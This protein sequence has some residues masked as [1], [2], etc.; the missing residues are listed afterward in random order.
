MATHL[1]AEELSN[2]WPWLKSY[3]E[4]VRWDI[5]VPFAPLWEVMDH[6]VAEFADKTAIDFLD[7]KYSYAD[8]GALV[9]KAAKG[10]QEIG[11]QKGVKVGLFLPNSPYTVI[12]FFAILKAGGTVVN[13]NPL[14]AERELASQIEDSETDIMVTLD[15]QVLYPRVETLMRNT[16][17]KRIIVCRMQ[18]SLPFPKNLLF[19]MVK[20]KDIA[21]VSSDDFVAHYKDLVGNDGRYTPVDVDVEEDVACLQYTGGT[22]GTPKGAM[23][24]HANLYGN[25]QQIDMWFHGREPGKERVVAV[26]PFFHVFGMTAIMLLGVWGGAEMVLL[27]RF[28]IDE[29]MQAIHKKKPTIFA[30]VP[31]MFTAM[32]NHPDRDKYDFTSLKYVNSGGASMPLEIMRKFEEKAGGAELRE[33]YGLSETSPVVSS[34]PFEGKRKAG[35]VGI[36]YPATI[37]QIVSLDDP[38]K[39]MPIGEQ[40]EIAVRGPQVM[41]GYWQKPEET[42]AVMKDGRFLTGDIGYMDDE[43]YLFIVDR[44]KEMIIAGGYNIYPR[45]VEEAIYEH[46]AVEEVAVIGVADEYR[47]ETVKAVIK[48]RAGESLTEEELT[49]FLQDKLSKIEQPKIVE[50]RD[51]ELPKT[52]VGKIQ[53]KILIEEEQAKAKESA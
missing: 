10:L 18:D 48:L 7:K 37:V 6:A 28:E 52:A 20:G 25:V 38:T 30:G 31:T 14:Y 8:L 11:V 49:E 15:L 35:S 27:P 2:E 43:G 40:G 50:F 33:G 19:P 3:P 26:L 45:N 21:K 1:S 34:N 23:L 36:P 4:G 47:G 44:K 41:K 13:Y 42:D 22:T 29:V 32:V 12:F 17:L 51:T 39:V 5:E 53:K 9:N 46:P 16:R 24:T